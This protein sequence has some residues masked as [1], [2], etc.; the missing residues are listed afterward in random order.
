MSSTPQSTGV[1]SM[2]GKS[3]AKTET[4]TTNKQ[5]LAR[6]FSG[7][8]FWANLFFLWGLFLMIFHLPGRF[9]EKEVTAIDIVASIPISGYQPENSG[10]KNWRWTIHTRKVSWHRKMP[11]VNRK[12]IFKWMIFHCHVSFRVGNRFIYIFLLTSNFAVF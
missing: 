2:S 7:K 12:Y 6:I 11:I 10:G 1:K 8:E 4:N 3:I 9:L 5:S